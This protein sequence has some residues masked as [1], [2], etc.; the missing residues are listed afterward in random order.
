MVI[1]QYYIIE[2]IQLYYYNIFSSIG[3]YDIS[4]VF[5]K[6]NNMKSKTKLKSSKSKSI[7]LHN[8]LFFWRGNIINMD[9][10]ARPPLNHFIRH[11]LRIFRFRIGTQYIS[12]NRTR[13]Q[14]HDTI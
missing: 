9:T 4:I 12:V 10:F 2:L 5:A 13:L 7:H 1:L 3:F 6:D 14:T 11:C 8:Y